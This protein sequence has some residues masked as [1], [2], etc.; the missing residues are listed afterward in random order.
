MRL[1]IFVHWRRA[2]VLWEN[3]RIQWWEYFTFFRNVLDIGITSDYRYK[4]LIA[5]R[6]P[7]CCLGFLES[8]SAICQLPPFLKSAT[9][10]AHRIFKS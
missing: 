4:K 3:A 5:A 6:D 8:R 9:H 7:V 1:F 2:F 10:I